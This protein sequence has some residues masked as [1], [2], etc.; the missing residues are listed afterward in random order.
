MLLRFN[1]N[2]DNNNNDNNN[3]DNNNNNNNN[4]NN[5]DDDDDNNNFK[6]LENKC[7]ISDTYYYYFNLAQTK[8]QWVLIQKPR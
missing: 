8:A 5:N 6:F 2:N 4:D 1:N 3:N 7:N